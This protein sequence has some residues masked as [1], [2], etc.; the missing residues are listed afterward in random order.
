M[1][2]GFGG[3]FRPIAKGGSLLS[4]HRRLPVRPPVVKGA[5]GLG[6]LETHREKLAGSGSRLRAEKAWAIEAM[7]W[8]VVGTALISAPKLPLIFL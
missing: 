8:G 3:K 2:I 7:G 5:W 6:L 1:P 4:P